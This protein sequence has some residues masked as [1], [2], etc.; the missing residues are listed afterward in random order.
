MK[1]IR[2]KKHRLNPDVYIG[3]RPIA[4]TICT[5]DRA[6]IFTNHK[7]FKLFEEILIKELTSFNCCSFVHLFMPDHAHFV[8][9]GN[10]SNSE[11]KK[12]LD[13]FKQ[14]TGFYIAKNLK[15]IRWQKDYYDHILKNEENLEVHVKYILNNP[16]RA[17][18]VD[19]WKNY[20]YKGSTVYNLDEWD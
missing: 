8:L 17:G 20:P 4:F 6:T 2:E 18:L 11:V 9:G 15:N 5:K 14:K 13:M 7:I 10:D 19:Y 3:E 16:V 12:C 1:I